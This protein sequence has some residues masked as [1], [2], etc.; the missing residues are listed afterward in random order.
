MKKIIPLLALILLAS[1]AWAQRKPGHQLTLDQADSL[2]SADTSRLQVHGSIYAGFWSSCGMASSYTGAAPTLTYQ[3]R[4]NLW[5][6]GTLFAVG[7]HTMPS[8]APWVD[9]Q[10]PM[11][12]DLMMGRTGLLAYGGS[13][14]L[15]LKTKRDNHFSLHLTFVNDRA[16]L[17][18]PYLFS[19][20]YHSYLW[21][22]TL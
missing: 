22:T 12:P 16:G 21:N 9:G 10:P 14:S 3:L 5:L 13:L 6:S 18:S 11:A 19:P 1:P 8:F 17:L 15:D 2:A 7:G 20:Y 4:D